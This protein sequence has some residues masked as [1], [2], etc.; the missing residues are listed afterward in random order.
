MLGS[1]VSS[2]MLSLPPSRSVHLHLV[3][4]LPSYILSPELSSQPFLISF[5]YKLYITPT[6]NL[7]ALS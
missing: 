4:F 5:L 2:Y 7:Q 1:S 6:Q 3:F